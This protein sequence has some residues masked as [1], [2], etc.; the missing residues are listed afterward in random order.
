MSDLYTALT[1]KVGARQGVHAICSP[2]G[3]PITELAELTDGL[4]VVVL[5]SGFRFETTPLPHK[6]LL[7]I[8]QT[9]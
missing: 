8:G 9:E 2:Q 3:T 1:T 7:K 6:L 5:P 4:D